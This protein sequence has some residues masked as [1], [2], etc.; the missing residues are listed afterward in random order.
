MG[1]CAIETTFVVIELA[2][3]ASTPP[4]HPSPAAVRPAPRNRDEDSAISRRPRTDRAYPSFAA[5]ISD[6]RSS[7]RR[8]LPVSVLG[9]S[10]T[11]SIL[12][13]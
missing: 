8:I 7:I 10:V 4:T 6:W 3:T 2:R 12:R 13:G 5:S 11:N 1:L 9:S